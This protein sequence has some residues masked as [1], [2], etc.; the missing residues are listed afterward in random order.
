MDAETRSLT[1]RFKTLVPFYEKCVY[2]TEPIVRSVNAHLDHIIPVSK[3]GLATAENLVWAC[4]R[5]NLAKRDLALMV[6]LRRA[7]LDVNEVIDRLH[8]LGKFV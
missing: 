2:C 8:R 1:E 5:C 6:F 3:G 7:G 4:D